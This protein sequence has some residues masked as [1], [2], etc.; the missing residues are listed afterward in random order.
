MKED[1]IKIRN[2]IDE[3]DSKIVE[4]YE[5][6][7]KMSERV[8]KYKIENQKAVLDKEREKIK[9][10]KVGDLTTSE[11]TRKCIIDLYKQIMSMSRERQYQLLTENGKIE[12]PNFTAVEELDFSNSKIVF[13]G[14]SG[15]YTE[16]AMKEYFGE[17]CDNFHVNTWKEAMEALKNNEAD[18]AV[19]PYENSSAGIVAENFDLLVEYDN[20]IVGEQIIKIEHSLLGQKGAKIENIKKIFSH[21]QA[22]MQCQKFV[23][24]HKSINKISMKNTAMAAKKIKED[25]DITQ[26][27]I[28]SKSSAKIYDLD[29]I[30]ESIQDNKENY[31]KFII[32]TNKKIYNKSAK[33]ISVCFEAPHESGSLYHMLSHI[34]YNNLNMDMIQSRPI[35]EKNWKYRFFV[36][37]EGNLEDAAVINALVAL[38]QDAVSFRI[39]GNY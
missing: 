25:N 11:Y 20:F 37:F 2:E 4:L 30:Q 14:V 29:I 10:Q 15:A 7:M 18:Y 13:Q 32:V 12:K 1:L 9:L 8:A 34:I 33:K 38:K 36:N 24:K 19:F 16:L 5:A 21:P 3:I 22:F 39:L 31:T 23:D 35:K 17:N 26:A 27:A 28:A 6:R